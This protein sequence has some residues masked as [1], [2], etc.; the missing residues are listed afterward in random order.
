[1]VLNCR[2]KEVGN[3][4]CE[5]GF[6]DGCIKYGQAPT[7]TSVP[8]MSHPSLV[9]HYSLMNVR[10]IADTLCIFILR[11]SKQFLSWPWRAERQC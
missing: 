7:K 8:S 1:M 4:P 2:G 11:V 3:C 10:F 6:K 9:L 5:T